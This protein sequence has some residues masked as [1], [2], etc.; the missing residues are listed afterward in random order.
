MNKL[1]LVKSNEAKLR[2]SVDRLTD[3]PEVLILQVLSHMDMKEVVQTSFLST[4]WRFLWRSVPDLKFIFFGYIERNV[5]VEFVNEIL[6]RH[7]INIDEF[8]L[9]SYH[10]GGLDGSCIKSWIIKALRRHVRRLF[11]ESYL[12]SLLDLPYHLFTSN[13]ETMQ[14]SF[15]KSLTQLPSS[16]CMASEL[17][18]LELKGIK[19]PN[20]NRK[21]ELIVSWSNL[22]VA[23]IEFCDFT[24]IRTLTISAPQLK[25]F[26][27]R[28]HDKEGSFQ[29]NISCPNLKSLSWASGCS[30]DCSPMKIPTMVSAD[31]IVF[32]RNNLGK[33]ES[34]RRWIKVLTGIPYVQVLTVSTY[35][36]KV[37]TDYPHLWELVPFF[38]NLRYVVFGDKDLCTYAVV[39][40]LETLHHKRTLGNAQGSSS[41]E[42]E[43]VEADL[44]LKR[45]L[46]Y[47][48]KT[49]SEITDPLRV[50]ME[51]KFLTL[52]LK[53]S[54]ILKGMSSGSNDMF[55]SDQTQL[56]SIA[57]SF[58]EEDKFVPVSHFVQLL[59]EAQRGNYRL[60]PPPCT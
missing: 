40:S 9:H 26:N 42:A 6:S 17:K 14:L 21:G 49:Y 16:L 5:F 29:L 30:M 48:R 51:L 2:T 24:H 15:A 47:P 7:H 38:H 44:F 20:G 60:P 33:E 46:K 54:V 8:H 37:L 12:T 23:R 53:R 32:I 39:N 13:V 41:A 55:L 19:F 4:K 27:F 31:I 45:I 22:E 10:W 58:W 25:I 57:V 18:R 11:V 1:K 28:S 3:L 36:L 52:L 50:E 34:A 43:Y 35:Y 56:R 59:R